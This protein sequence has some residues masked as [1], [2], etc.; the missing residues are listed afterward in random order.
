MVNSYKIIGTLNFGIKLKRSFF[1]VMLLCFMILT[2]ACGI[3]II[4]NSVNLIGLD[5]SEFIALL[6]F[7]IIFAFVFVFIIIF[8]LRQIFY[9]KNK[10]TKY[11]EDPLLYQVKAKIYE[12]DKTGF[13]WYSKYK[14]MATFCYNK[15]VLNIVSKSYNKQYKKFIGKKTDIYY[16]PKYKQ[17]LLLEE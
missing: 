2:L 3:P 7:L 10:I 11:L 16:S 13:G 9:F 14:I 15:K 5:N 8:W 4:F 6:I 17:V 1:I 12:C